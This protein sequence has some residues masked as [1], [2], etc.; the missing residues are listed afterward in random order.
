M[1][2]RRLTYSLHIFTLGMLLFSQTS[3]AQSKQSDSGANVTGIYSNLRSYQETGDVGGIEIFVLYSVHGYYALVQ[4]AEGGPDDPT[5][6][7]ANV[8]GSSI[9][10]DLPVGDRLVKCR[11]TFTATGLKCHF[12]KP[13]SDPVSGKESFF[14]KRTNSYW[15]P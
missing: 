15:Q 2:I 1:F 11:G 13:L 12:E 8:N 6:V 3:L 9:E 10:F 5:L 4:F 14:L 7:K